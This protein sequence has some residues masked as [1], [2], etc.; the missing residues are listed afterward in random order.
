MS[1]PDITD[2][3]PQEAA[4]VRQMVLEI[5]QHP[6]IREPLMRFLLADDFP[7]LVA[8]VR[9]NSDNIK[10]ILERLGVVEEAVQRIPAIE[11]AVQRI[12]AIEE[13]VQRIPAIEEAVQ[14]IPA[15]E[16]AVQRIPAIEEAVQ[17]IPA[18]EKAV[19]RIPAIEKTIERIPAIEKTIERIPAIEKTIECIPAL[20]R[21]VRVLQGHVGRLL[22]NSYEDQCARQIVAILDGF[23]DRAVLADRERINALLVE[24]R[25]AGQISRAELI[26]G[27]NCDIIARGREDGDET[28]TLAV[29]EASITFNR[30]DLE[31]AARRAELIGR[32]AGV[33]TDAYLVTHHEWP[34]A[35]DVAA[36]EL[37]VTIISYPI[38][39]YGVE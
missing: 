33:A 19:Q 12:P 21:S 11:E 31:T 26:D 1:T 13:A 24:A 16:E 37:N 30:Q 17:R 9:E 18:I 6:R 34:E 8:M 15:I 32:I 23:M 29:A 14:R 25:H 3:I 36:R 27:Y 5:V 20:E 10:L 38:S 4:L 39:D 22:G 28:V 35:M 2:L 7:N